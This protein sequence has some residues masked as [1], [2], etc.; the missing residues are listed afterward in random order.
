VPGGQL[1]DLILPEDVFELELGRPIAVESRPRRYGL[2]VPPGPLIGR[3]REL[4]E[5]CAVLRAPARVLT[6]TGP[7]GTGK[8]RIAV[9][10]ADAVRSDFADGVAFVPLAPIIDPALVAPT[11]CHALGVNPGAETS[12]VATLERELGDKE[13]LLLLDNFEQ[14][15]PAGPIVA[16]V[17]RSAPAVKALVTSR[18]P[19]RLSGEHEYE[20]PPLWTP[21]T[22]TVASVE[23]LMS[24]DAVA[25]F[26]SRAQAAKSDFELDA[27]NATAVVQLCSRL[28]GLPLALELAATRVKVLSPEAMVARLD[29][30]LPHVS[31]PLD[32]P[33]HQR[34]LRA[35]IEWSHGLLDPFEQRLFARLGVFAGGFVLEAAEAVCGDGGSV[36]ILDGL[37]SLVDV[38][39]LRGSA[40]GAPG[41]RFAMLGTI[42]AYAVER[43]GA[44]GESAV[45]SRRHAEHFVALV[46]RAEPEIRRGRDLKWLELLEDEHDNVRAAL[47]WALE[48]G[49]DELLA[50]LAAAQARFWEMRGYLNEGRQWLE[51]AL[52]KSAGS[53]R[54]RILEG[55]GTLADVQGDPETARSLLEASLA[56]YRESGDR[57]GMARALTSFAG[58]LTEA[59]DFERARRLHEQARRHFRE[60]GNRRAEAVVAGNLG[61]LALVQRD[62]DSA[63]RHLTEA[64]DV[65]RDLGDLGGVA[66]GLQNVG[67]SALLRGRDEAALDA[68]R[69]CL[70]LSGSTRYRRTIAY[71]LVGI[72]AILRGR[73]ELERAARLVGAADET[74]ESIGASFEPVE[75]DLRSETVAAL[76]AK[77]GIKGL[78]RGLAEGRALGLE[79][80]IAEALAGDGASPQP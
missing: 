11:I 15:R 23:E 49:E 3:A 76:E 41:P 22:S 35:T 14:L 45:V 59:G 2:P 72:A 69:Q 21:T 42:R 4:G 40:G 80:A 70:R 67:F 64:T 66:V 38:S 77:L 54:A 63:D 34:T 16:E 53:I 52:P 31:G 1:Q 57:D 71:A 36:N 78:E 8:T 47:T 48:N 24:Y 62:Y 56:L 6:L 13:L 17:L 65:L 44:S 25:F 5:I 75:R 74:V 79:Q 27:G 60:L 19:L 51:R 37:A 28:D 26:V 39:L 50:R 46:E 55:L 43:L 20:L 29:E 61:Y 58:A 33:A 7:G 32:R 9:A 73:G 18:A 68:L 10:A 12:A 30:W